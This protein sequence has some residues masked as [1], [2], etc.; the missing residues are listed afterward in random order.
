MTF[1]IGLPILI[2][3][4]CLLYATVYSLLCERNEPLLLKKKY[5]KKH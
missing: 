1:L 4:L 3:A 2:I 5:R